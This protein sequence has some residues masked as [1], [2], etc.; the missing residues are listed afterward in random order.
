[1]RIRAWQTFLAVPK[2]QIIQL[3]QSK[4]DNNSKKKLA[5]DSLQKMHP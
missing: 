3:K 1:M 2:L 5:R 4:L